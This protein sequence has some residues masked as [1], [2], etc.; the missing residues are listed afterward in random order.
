MKFSFFKRKDKAAEPSSANDSS[1]SQ[2]TN[3]I[4]HSSSHDAAGGPRRHRPRPRV[5]GS[6]SH[7]LVIGIDFGTTYSGVSY[8]LI[9]PGKPPEDVKIK[10]VILDTLDRFCGGKVPSKVGLERGG[11]WPSNQYGSQFDGNIHWGF[12]IPDNCDVFQWMKILLEPFGTSPNYQDS[13]NVKATKELLNQYGLTAVEIVSEYLKLIWEKAKEEIISDCTRRIFDAAEKTVVLSVPAGW[14]EKATQNTYDAAAAAFRDQEIDCK[15][16]LKL[17]NEPAAAA[18]HVLTQEKKDNPEL[19]KQDDCVIVCDA[20]GG[21][22]DVVTF[23]VTKMD[24]HL[25]LEE[26]VAPKGELCGSIY[27]EK[28]FEQILSAR[29]GQR[30]T[31]PCNEAVENARKIVTK[32]FA[33]KLKIQFDMEPR[34]IFTIPFYPPIEDPNQPGTEISDLRFAY[35][36]FQGIFDPIC[37][38]IYLL[39]QSQIEKLEERNLKHKLKAVVLVGGL[40]NSKYLRHFL[41]GQLA[42]KG[43]AELKTMGNGEGLAS[44]AKGAVLA[45]AIG[46]TRI[47]NV[48][49]A[50]H[51]IGVEA[52]QDYSPRIHD[53][54]YRFVHETTGEDV[55]NTVR[56][57]V[58]MGSPIRTNQTKEIGFIYTMDRHILDS[59]NLRISV[60]PRLVLCDEGRPMHPVTG[61]RKFVSVEFNVDKRHILQSPSLKTLT[62]KNGTTWYYGKVVTDQP[63]TVSYYE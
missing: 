39:I 5:D 18:I 53:K 4:T 52:Y 31:G 45:E 29:I 44:V 36:T 60:I 9:H 46:I 22:V 6:N 14:S 37:H 61:V 49:V 51:N 17:I 41:K 33:D 50:R 13:P 8:A 10:Q 21:T 57:I 11:D 26:I 12:D 42:E 25:V 32:E 27:L 16:N 62:K 19:I 56:W 20:G 54:R 3:G 59:E 58:D 30:G 24:P 43:S 63:L 23:Q 1:P 7:R 38:K 48:F 15:N 34:R 40:G 47:F 2:S 35:D 55:V 28:G